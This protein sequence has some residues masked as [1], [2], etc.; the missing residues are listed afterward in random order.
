MNAE[1]KTISLDER[2]V[3]KVLVGT[4]FC[5]ENEFVDMRLSVLKQ[6]NVEIH[7]QIVTFLPELQAHQ[8]LY[9]YWE[10]NKR[11][12][13]LFVQIDADMVLKSENAVSEAANLLMNS[14]ERGNNSIVCLLHDWYM[15]DLIQGIRFSHPSVKYLCPQNNLFPDRNLDNIST[16]VV[17]G[18]EPLNPIGTHSENPTLIQ[19]F[20]Y[21]LHRG[22]KG[23]SSHTQKILTEN[24]KKFDVRRELAL[25]GFSFGE[26]NKDKNS[27]YSDPFF[28]ESY[29][30]AIGEINKRRVVRL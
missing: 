22:M 12:F 3:Y 11:K 25:I 6:K 16:L 4:M 19:A 1:I 29:M 18:G 28:M 8:Q 21:G 9:S 15:N 20:R 7:H 17:T 30:Q 13:D 24:E 14:V 5:G 26:K 2:R 27:S 23:Y 10:E